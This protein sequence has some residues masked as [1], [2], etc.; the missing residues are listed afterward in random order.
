MGV[1]AGLRQHRTQRAKQAVS[2]VGNCKAT[3]GG[4]MT[5]AEVQA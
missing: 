4:F 2:A 1:A 5:C 3:A